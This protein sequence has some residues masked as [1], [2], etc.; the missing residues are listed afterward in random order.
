MRTDRVHTLRLAMAR[1]LL[2]VGWSLLFD[3]TLGRAQQQGSPKITELPKPF[4]TIQDAKQF[5]AVRFGPGNTFSVVETPPD[6]HLYTFALSPDGS[7]LA[8]GWGSGRIELWDLHSKKRVSEFKSDAGA[9]GVIEFDKT[10]KQLIVTGSGGKLAIL[11][12]P[13]GKKLKSWTIPLGKYKYDLHEIVLDP[14]GRWLAYADEEDSKVL[15]ISADPPKQLADLK[16]AYSL[17]L[18][19]DG[20]TLWTV[21]RN[22]LAGF[23]TDTWDVMGQWPLKS[24]QIPTSVAVVRAGVTSNGQNTIAVPS[25]KGLIFYRPPNM[26]GTYATDKPTSAVAFIYGR[27]IFVNF[28]GALTFLSDNGMALCEKSYKHRV[29]YAISGDGQ[30]LAIS[31]FNGVDLWRVEDLL[32]DCGPGQ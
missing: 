22:E 29:D 25:A 5:N 21:N 32:R 16:D 13:K 7:L 2:F 28:S 17:A 9:P 3:T 11:D 10:G 14:K 19:N 15:D 12:L 26:E 31:E 20:H 8:M 1:R 18:S 27:N 4:E 30:W 6:F 23:N 24:S